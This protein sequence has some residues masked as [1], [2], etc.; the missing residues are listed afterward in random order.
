[1]NITFKKIINK[2]LTLIL[3]EIL[4]PKEIEVFELYYPSFKRLKTINRKL[5]GYR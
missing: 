2:A 4:M 1:M 5:K 3:M